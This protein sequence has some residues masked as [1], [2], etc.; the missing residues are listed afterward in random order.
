MSNKVD[1]IKL[2]DKYPKE[3]PHTIIVGRSEEVGVAS[4][5]IGIYLDGE[6]LVH[7]PMGLTEFK[8]PTHWAEMIEAPEG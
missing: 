4:V 3:S 7:S 1:W 8:N 2:S 5:M 6:F